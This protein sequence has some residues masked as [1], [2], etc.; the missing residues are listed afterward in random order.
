MAGGKGGHVVGRLTGQMGG[1]GCSVGRWLTYGIGVR[2]VG[3]LLGVWLGW[4]DGW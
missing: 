2:W 4:L 3:G 1:L